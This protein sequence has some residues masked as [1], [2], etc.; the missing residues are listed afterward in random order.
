MALVTGPPALPSLAQCSPQGHKHAEKRG[1]EKG[2]TGWYKKEDKVLIPEAQQ[3]K[4]TKSLHDAT[5]HG[6]DAPW[7]LIEKASSGEGL[8]RPVKQATLACDLCT[9]NN[10][11][12]HPMPPSLL[13]SNQRRGTYLGED[14]QLDFTQM[15]P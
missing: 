9:H 8:K 7:D 6:R 15:L 5:H 3:R 1:S 12:T 4:L 2:S 13:R 10:P 14:W 11:Q